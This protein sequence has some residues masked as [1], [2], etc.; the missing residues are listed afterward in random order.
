MRSDISK[1]YC[2]V[3]KGM[4]NYIRVIWTHTLFSNCP[5]L[6]IILRYLL[7]VSYVYFN[8]RNDTRLL[9]LKGKPL[10]KSFLLASFWLKANIRKVMIYWQKLYT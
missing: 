1:R 4:V 3:Q 6:Q 5:N 10:N 7:C 2:C 8:S 9:K